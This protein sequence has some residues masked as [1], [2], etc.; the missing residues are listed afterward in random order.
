MTAYAG[1]NHDGFHW[2]MLVRER[3]LPGRCGAFVA[4]LLPLQH[5][6]ETDRVSYRHL[7][8][9]PRRHREL[10]HHDADALSF[11]EGRGAQLLPDLRE[12]DRVSSS[13]RDEPRRG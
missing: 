9:L 3:A 10:A 12:H 11:V 8:R 1:G 6:P 2:R 13:A 4:L 5:V 7:R